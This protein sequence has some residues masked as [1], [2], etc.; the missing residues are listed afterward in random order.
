LLARERAQAVNKRTVMMVE[1]KKRALINSSDDTRMLGL[2][3]TNQG[4]DNPYPR[5]DP[6]ESSSGGIGCHE[7]EVS[8]VG[9]EPKIGEEREPSS[10]ITTT[11]RRIKGGTGA[12]VKRQVERPLQQKTT[13][14]RRR[15]RTVM[16]RMMMMTS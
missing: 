13:M 7:Q 11:K 2:L 5:R 4:G 8:L 14:R 9:L 1:A 3:S 16:S 12:G 6:N 10:A 15:R